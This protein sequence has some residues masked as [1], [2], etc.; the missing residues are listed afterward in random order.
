MIQDYCSYELHDKWL[1]Y[2]LQSIITTHSWIKESLLYTFSKISA[3]YSF[4]AKSQVLWKGSFKRI[5]REEKYVLMKIKGIFKLW[6][7]WHYTSLI[8]SN[9]IFLQ[10]LSKNRSCCIWYWCLYICNWINLILRTCTI[11]CK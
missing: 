2:F 4:Q 3:N 1:S 8:N 7:G 10:D 11:H 6:F 9:V 5:V